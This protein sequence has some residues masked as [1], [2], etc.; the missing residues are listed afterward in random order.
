MAGLPM[1]LPNRVICAA[2]CIVSAAD[3]TSASAD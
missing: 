1:E 2:I 3:P